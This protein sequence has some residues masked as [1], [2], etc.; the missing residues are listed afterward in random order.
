VH[1]LELSRTPDATDPLHCGV[2]ECFEVTGFRR[3]YLRLCPA[4]GQFDPLGVI[5]LVIL[6]DFRMRAIRPTS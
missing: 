3:H 4:E 1:H 5:L 6:V 2:Q